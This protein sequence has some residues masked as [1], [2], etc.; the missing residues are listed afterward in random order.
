LNSTLACLQLLWVPPKR[1]P[2]QKL[3]APAGLA[4]DAAGNLYIADGYLEGKEGRILRVESST[5]KITTV[6]SN[7]PQP[8]SLAFQSPGVLCFSEAGAHQVRCLNLENG[9][10]R[11]FAGT[12]KA[13]L[14]GDGGS[15]EC[16]Q[17]N[18]PTGI[19]FDS[20]GNLYI[21]DT[22]NQRIRLVHPGTAAAQ[23]PPNHR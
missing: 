17:L 14:S 4:L 7:L 3:A 2:V 18:R 23:C 6:L 12:G 10:I 21:A 19:S 16:A 22:G 5:R 1:L 11:V 9:S 20:L 13:G 8:S 15:A